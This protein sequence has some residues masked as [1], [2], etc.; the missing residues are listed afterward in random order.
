[1]KFLKYILPAI[2]VLA[3]FGVVATSTSSKAFAT[4]FGCN[5]VNQQVFQVGSCLHDNGAGVITSDGYVTYN[6]IVTLTNCTIYLD[7]RDDSIQ[8]TVS[9]N[10]YGCNPTWNNQHLYGTPVTESLFDYYH[11]YIH[12]VNNGFWSSPVNSPEGHR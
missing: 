2:A 3:V 4:G 8:N 11:G 10:S 12:Y 6:H 5:T 9:E 7:L 1:M